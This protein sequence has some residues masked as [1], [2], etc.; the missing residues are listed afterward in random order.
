MT[1]SSRRTAKDG[2]SQCFLKRREGFFVPYFLIVLGLNVDSINSHSFLRI[3]TSMG[4]I[5]VQLADSH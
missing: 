4:D 5:Q 2:L 3:D 1:E